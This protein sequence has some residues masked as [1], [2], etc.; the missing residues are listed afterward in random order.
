MRLLSFILGMLI[1]L[2]CVAAPLPVLDRDN[3]FSAHMMRHTTLLLIAAPLLALA[4]APDN[5][6]KDRLTALSRFLG[7]YPFWAWITGIA[8]M[9]CWHL[10]AVYNA[11]PMHEMPI[12]A[13]PMPPMALHT[14]P[15]HPGLD[16]K[17][18]V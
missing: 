13:M 16:R 6:A 14:M 15:L 12:H 3:P 7:R 11:M 18:V 17:S 2:A 5:A 9:W 4:I 10:P 1:I 8:I